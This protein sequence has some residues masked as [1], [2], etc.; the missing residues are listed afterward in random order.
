MTPQPFLIIFNPAAGRGVAARYQEP[1]RD[2]LRQSRLPHEFVVTSAPGEAEALARAARSG[3]YRAVVAAGG[4]GTINEVANGLLGGTVPLGLIPIGTGNDTAKMLDLRPNALRA[5][6]VRLH[7]GV[8]RPIDVGLANGRAFVNGLGIGFDAAV[9]YATRRPTRL[10]GFGVY[11]KAVLTTFPVFTPPRLHVTFPDLTIERRLLL[12]TVANGRSQ[13]GGFVLTPDAQLNDS[14][15]DVCMIDALSTGEFVRHV[16]K[17]LW[18][19]HTHLPQVRMLR[20]TAVA[21]EL[22]DAFPVHLDGELLG[23]D[24]HAVAVTIQPHALLLLS[25]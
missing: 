9:S 24:L 18:G 1:L 6:L 5:A 16:P 17:V 8:A 23:D 21:I 11:V 2:L 20:T 10:R 12:L 3:D 22:A 4:D 15:L 13:G 19:G 7:Y 25:R 14:L